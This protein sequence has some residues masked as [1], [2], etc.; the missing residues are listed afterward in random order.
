M[1][2]ALAGCRSPAAARTD[3]ASR[4]R[5]WCSTSPPTR[6]MRASTR[7]SPAATTS[8]AGVHLHVSSRRPST[9]SI[10]LLETGRVNFAILD[11]HDLAIARERG[12][13]IV[14]I[15]AIVQRPLAAVIAAPQIA[16][17]RELAGQTVGVTGVPERHGRAAL[18]RRRRRRRPRAV[19]TIT[20][21]FNAV[22]GPARRPGRRR[23]RVLERR[24]RDRARHDPRF[25]VFRVDQYGAPSYPR[26]GRVRDRLSCAPTRGWRARSCA[27]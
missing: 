5:R 18:D 13:D 1:R 14:G 22:A 4:T 15:M 8:R 11:I 2:P 7:R 25:H 16:S 17:P 19:K 3:G 9:D 10:R 23:D 6:S 21:G 20:I 26:A 27:R 24:G 12:Q